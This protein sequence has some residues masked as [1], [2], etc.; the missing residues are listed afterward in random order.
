MLKAGDVA[1][2]FRVKTQD[3]NE[4]A[5]SDFQNQKVVLWFFPKAD[6]PGC[7]IEGC[8]FRDRMTKFKEK[9]AVVMGMSFDTP[10][11]NKKFTE[12]FN[13]PFILLLSTIAHF[14]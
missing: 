14:I 4:I 7:T 5:L 2:D 10:K 13:F 3:G 12:K 9:N 11:D 1:P 8:G 6:T